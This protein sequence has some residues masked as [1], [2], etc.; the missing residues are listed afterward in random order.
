MLLRLHEASWG[1]VPGSLMTAGL[2]ND[3]IKQQ[4]WKNWK[5]NLKNG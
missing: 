2:K 1:R 5:K 3:A 4:D